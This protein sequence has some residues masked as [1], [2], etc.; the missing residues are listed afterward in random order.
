MAG[1]R[2][3][4][5]NVGLHPGPLL[6]QGG[7]VDRTCPRPRQAPTSKQLKAWEGQA[8]G[9]VNLQGRRPDKTFDRWRLVCSRMPASGFYERL[10]DEALKS[11][12]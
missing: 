1:G 10:M 12:R 2:A 3:G 7:R 4:S 9:G 11:I 5:E 8:S 6:L